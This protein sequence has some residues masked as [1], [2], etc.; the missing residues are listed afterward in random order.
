MKK[1]FGQVYKIIGLNDIWIMKE[2]EVI[3]LGS[4]EAVIYLDLN[5]FD[6]SKTVQDQ[7][8]H[9][10]TSAIGTSDN[11]FEIEKAEVRVLVK[12]TR[13]KEST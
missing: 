5:W 8:M 3:K 9:R 4:D 11:V 6:L 12:R 10:A 7:I 13:Q 1:H 2:K